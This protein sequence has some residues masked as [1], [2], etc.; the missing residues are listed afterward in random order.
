MP[1]AQK[2]TV[3]VSDT[4]DLVDVNRMLL[5]E[6]QVNNRIGVI[7]EKFDCGEKFPHMGE[8]FLQFGEE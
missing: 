5:Y 1:E 3:S 6:V 8:K 4:Q 7:S 2:S